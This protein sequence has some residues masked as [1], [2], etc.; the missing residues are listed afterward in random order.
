MLLEIYEPIMSNIL[1]LIRGRNDFLPSGLL[2][3]D[4]DSGHLEKL[5][6]SRFRSV[7]LLKYI[8]AVDPDALV[9]CLSSHGSARGGTKHAYTL[10]LPSTGIF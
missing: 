5:R 9:C 1:G 10:V 2:R 7:L 4:D 6:V 3:R 8:S